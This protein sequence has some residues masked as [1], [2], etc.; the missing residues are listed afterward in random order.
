MRIVTLAFS[1]HDLP[2]RPASL[3]GATVATR[4]G[5]YWRVNGDEARGDERLLTLWPIN[6]HDAPLSGRV[7]RLPT[8]RAREISPGEDFMPRPVA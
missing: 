4:E 1:G 5:V 8:H 2:Q 6:G 3:A 7:E